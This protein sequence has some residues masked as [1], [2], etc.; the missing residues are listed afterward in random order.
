[1]KA[2]IVFVKDP[3]AGKVKTRLQSH[4]SP[5]KIVEI[6]KSFV[7]EILSKC[8]RLKGMDKFLGCSPAKDDDFLKGLA[9][10]YKMKSFNQRG[11]DLGERI[12]NA[13]KFCLKKGYSEI[14]L[15][16]SDSP[17]I[18][19]DFIKKAF[20]QLTR[21]DFV[22]GP[23]CDCGLYLIGAKRGKVNEIFR[24]IELDTGGDVNE[25]LKKMNS[26]NVSFFMLPFWY[27]IDTIEDLRF[28]ENH[29]TYLDKKAKK[30]G[31]VSV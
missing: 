18:P 12:S 27:D 4:L 15:I 26:M 30:R 2:L 28:F 11:K 25:I 17:T 29:L 5:D 24:S 6:Y 31:V 13:F 10:K 3:V 20:L 8:S 7:T 16:G 1:M 21:N 22:I 14:I 23:C 19:V 9:T